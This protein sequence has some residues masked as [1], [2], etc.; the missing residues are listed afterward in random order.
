MT[1]FFI[2]VVR[3][4]QTGMVRGGRL[5]RAQFKFGVAE[6][7]PLASGR[8]HTVHAGGLQ[9]ILTRSTGGPHLKPMSDEPIK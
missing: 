2:G 4:T 7:P 8:P 6:I 5:T 9:L 1:A 3:A